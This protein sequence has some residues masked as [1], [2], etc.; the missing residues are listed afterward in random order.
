MVNLL[1]LIMITLSLQIG[2]TSST[3]PEVTPYNDSILIF[4]PNPLRGLLNG[5]QIKITFHGLSGPIRLDQQLTKEA[6]LVL[7][8]WGMLVRIKNKIFKF[9][10]PE[11]FA[12]AFMDRPSNLKD[13]IFSL[14]PHGNIS[15]VV[16]GGVKLDLRS[17]LWGTIEAHLDQQT[18]AL[19][20]TL[21]FGENGCIS[22]ATSLVPRNA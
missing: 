16:C 11:F 2:V 10:L 6:I 1:K 14:F 4:C 18:R 9:F 5:R 22:N 13:L 12:Y 3:S 19:S 20:F 7:T 17:D 15:A 8:K 21:I